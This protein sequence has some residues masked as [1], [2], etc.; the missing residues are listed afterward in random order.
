MANDEDLAAV[1][2]PLPT[3]GLAPETYLLAWNPKL[4]EWEA[5]DDQIRVVRETGKA[6]DRWSC[7]RARNIPPGSRFFLIRR[8]A[9]PRG[10]VGCGSTLAKVSAAPHWNDE[11]AS[12]G[13]TTHYVEVQFDMLSRTPLIRRTEL[14]KGP[15]SGFAWDTQMSGVRI[16]D[17]VARSL[18][19]AWQRRLL[20][21]AHGE[22]V[23]P[24]EDESIER[25]RERWQTAR[26][27]NAWMERQRL[28]DEKRKQA[29]PADP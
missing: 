3:T 6:Q 10:I 11:R 22:V 18:D 1:R 4:F 17:D 9:E 28:R 16:P 27:D 24:V 19:Q 25:W 21:R 2:Q 20:A 14:D 5:L 8:G 15:F 23:A 29:L 7:G 26:L 12:Q 13:E